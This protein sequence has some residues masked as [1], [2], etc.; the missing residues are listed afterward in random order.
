[1]TMKNYTTIQEFADN[2]DFTTKKSEASRWAKERGREVRD[3]GTM[4]NGS[5]GLQAR[6]G[7]TTM[8]VYAVEKAR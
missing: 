5:Y 2:H 4:G 6:R 3:L 7:Q 8:H 1:M